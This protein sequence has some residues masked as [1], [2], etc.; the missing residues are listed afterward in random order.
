MTTPNWDDA[1]ILHLRSPGRLNGAA[2]GLCGPLLITEVMANAD[3]EDSGEFIDYNAGA[4]TIDL[5]GLVF[6]DSD[7][8]D[9]L[10]AYDW[11]APPRGWGHAVIVDAEFDGDFTID[12]ATTVV[13]TDTTL[14]NS[15]QSPTPSRCTKPM[16]P[17]STS[18]STHRTPETR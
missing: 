15:W 13:T 18:S 9:T 11:A 8:F 10:Q 7:A 14:G 17:S 6:S 3:D 2:G 12:S 1:T 4:E 16:P 5:A